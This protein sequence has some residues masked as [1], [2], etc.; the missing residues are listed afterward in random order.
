M[1]QIPKNLHLQNLKL[2]MIDSKKNLTDE[3]MP[4]N[5]YQ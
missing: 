3:T 4:I 1:M 5:S 2:N